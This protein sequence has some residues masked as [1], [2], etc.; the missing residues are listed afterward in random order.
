LTAT[1]S[2]HADLADNRFTM[3]TAAKR[4]THLALLAV[5]IQVI[6]GALSPAGSIAAESVTVSTN[7]SGYAV[8]GASKSA[9]F[10]R[11]AGSWIQPRGSCIQG[12]ETYSVAWVGLGGFNR[13]SHALEQAGTALDCTRSGHATHSAWYELVPANPVTMSLAV[14]PGDLIAASV[15]EKQGRTILQVRDLTTHASRTVV[16]RASTLDL[17]SAEWIVEAPSIC[18]T[19][20][21]CT[22]LPL[23]NFGTVS[24]FDAS[25]D[26]ETLAR[27]AIDA[28][29]LQVTRLELRDYS[30][31]RSGPRET[32]AIAATG[33]ASALSA[34]GNAFTVTWRA[35]AGEGSQAQEPLPR[36]LTSAAASF[37][38]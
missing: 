13:G 18:L 19:S 25:V 24:F 30:N 33:V 21:R 15:A 35:L 9:R 27:A 10:D 34:A 7:W 14:H 1:L 37:R 17:S 31:G 16:R 5:G 8:T 26:T 3:T 29:A 20:G 12:E 2:T 11:A 32:A 23:T 38:R 22:P 6:A 4:L 36:G 28:G